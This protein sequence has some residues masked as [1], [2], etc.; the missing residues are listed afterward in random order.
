MGKQD[1][2]SFQLKVLHVRISFF[3][4]L[5]LRFVT[6]DISSG[7]ELL[8][9]Q[10][11]LSLRHSLLYLAELLSVET[12]LIYQYKI[13]FDYKKFQNFQMKFS[14]AAPNFVYFP[15]H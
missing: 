9:P 4:S 10:L 7:S 1:W 3:E 6:F 5:H 8:T 15:L 14:F 13:V 2:H 12:L 11:Q